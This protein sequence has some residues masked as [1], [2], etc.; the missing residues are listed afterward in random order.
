MGIVEGRNALTSAYV[1]QKLETIDTTPK[2]RLDLRAVIRHAGFLMG[3][4]GI[5]RQGNVLE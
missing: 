3:A 4:A 2:P 5:R 1:M